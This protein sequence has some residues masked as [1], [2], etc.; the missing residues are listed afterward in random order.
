MGSE[1]KLSGIL[2]ILSASDPG[3]C[4]VKRGVMP[5]RLLR[6]QR[7]MS[8]KFMRDTAPH[9]WAGLPSRFH[10]RHGPSC[11]LPQRHATTDA[12]PQSAL[13][14]RTQSCTPRLKSILVPATLHIR[15]WK[16]R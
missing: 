14:H 11:R 4:T 8:V 7:T 13:L 6:E 3:N 2:A 16:Q 5:Q 10:S 12:L 1:A 15:E 9:R